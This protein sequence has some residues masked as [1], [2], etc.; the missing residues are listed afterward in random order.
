MNKSIPTVFT[1]RLAPEIFRKRLLMEGFFTRDDVTEATIK[2]YFRVI[3]SELSLRTYAEP[4]VHSTG[5]QGKAVNQGF[6]AFVP[7]IDSGIYMSLWAGPR[8]VSI[9]V[10]TCA[11]FD[12]AKAL[13]R[14]R[15]FFGIG[16][17]DAM[18]F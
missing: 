8:F 1:P 10:Y 2:E 4:I 3:T 11:E 18:L 15:E 9:I 5:G 17:T 6:D 14:T 7:L 13:S 16:D 12:E